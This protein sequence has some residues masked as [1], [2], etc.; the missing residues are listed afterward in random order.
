[1]AVGTT[2][3]EFSDSVFDSTVFP[4][5][6]QLVDRHGMANFVAEIGRFFSEKSVDYRDSPKGDA[7]IRLGTLLVQ[8]SDQIDD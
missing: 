3:D 8:E 6:D 5:F 4:A 2:L 7:L 1:L